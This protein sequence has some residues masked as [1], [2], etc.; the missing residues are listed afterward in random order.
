MLQ[1]TLTV[2]LFLILFA[3]VGVCRLWS[4]LLRPAWVNWAL[5]P[6]TLVSEM[7]FILGTLITG[8]EVRWSRLVPAGGGK[9]RDGG[10]AGTQTSGGLR[11]V[12]P[13]VAA[14]LS[15]IACIAGILVVRW[16][17]GGYVLETFVLSGP[18]DELP[19]RLPGSWEGFWKLVAVQV[20]LLRGTCEFW[21]RLDWLSWRVVV[22]VYLSA[23]L[24]LRLAAPGRDLRWTL[25]AMAAI[26][27]G[28]ALAGAI[29]ARFETLLGD[30]WPLVTY[31]WSL[32][33]FLLVV[34][35]LLA[36]AVELVRILAGRKSRAGR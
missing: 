1:I 23:C 21:A 4:G 36:G 27:A 14:G 6:G 31:V 25:A 24:S 10:E 17:I 19:R 26:S 8:G 29:S 32:L 33:L 12:G 16:W 22:F 5:L 30:V 20:E 7:A 11:V 18:V 9:G 2:W 3:G 13:I 28:M 35:A 34:S 15:V